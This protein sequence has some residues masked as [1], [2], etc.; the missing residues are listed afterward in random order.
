M[1]PLDLASDEEGLVDRITFTTD[2]DGGR[3]GDERR[4]DAP[5]GASGVGW[6]EETLCVVESLLRA[7][8]AIL[9][10]LGRAAVDGREV[11]AQQARYCPPK[12]VNRLV[13]V[14]YH[15]QSGTCFWRRDELEQLE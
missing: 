2:D 4:A 3:L 15:D 10:L 14:A 13:R 11:A 12:P 9:Q 8:A 1:K 7:A 5:R 6:D